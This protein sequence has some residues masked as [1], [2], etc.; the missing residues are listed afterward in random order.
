MSQGAGSGPAPVVSWPD[1]PRQGTDRWFWIAFT[2][3]A[4]SALPPM[5]HSPLATSCTTDP[6]DSAHCLAFDLDHGVGDLADR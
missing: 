5:A 6:G 1:P 4:V 2:S 3:A